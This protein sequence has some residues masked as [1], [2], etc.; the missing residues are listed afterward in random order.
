MILFKYAMKRLLQSKIKMLILLAL[1]IL[2]VLMFLTGSNPSLSVAVVD[3]DNSALSQRLIDEIGGITNVR[4]SVMDDADLDDKIVSFQENYAIII[5]KGFEHNIRAGEEP[6]VNE[7]YILE[8][9][10]IF[11]A[12]AL[13][14][15][16]IANMKTLAAG[17]AYDDAGFDAALAAYEESTLTVS[18]ESA[19][20]DQT[21]QI[22]SALGFLV[23]FMLYMSLITAGIILNDKS[24]GVYYRV[25]YAP[26]SLR[27]YLSENLLAF[28]LI[29]TLQVVFVLTFLRFALGYTLGSH[30]LAMYVLFVVFAFVCISLGM[31][32]ISL[33]K[34]PIFA[35]GSI[36]IL[37]VPMVMLGGCYWPVAYMPD[38]LIKIGKFLPTTW[39]MQG[40]SKL[41]DGG[42]GLGDIAI[43]ILILLLFAGIFMAAGLVTKV[44][45]SKQ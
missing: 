40:A 22:S 2:F 29:G 10:K 24:T 45:V 37:S 38:I 18:N 9:E 25:F 34:K 44:D 15:R 19:P 5:E 42:A 26:V 35:Y 30:L 31:W 7:F 23:Q 21:L 41:L 20:H 4:V 1:P 17:T 8:N 43:E 11:Y 3:K 39:V 32:L 12:R 27:R 28:M 33:F 14:D 6:A 13:I 16:Y 36:M